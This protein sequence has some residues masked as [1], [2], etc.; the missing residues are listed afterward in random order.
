MKNY[1]KSLLFVGLSVGFGACTDLDT[2]VDNRYTTLP[3]NPI[4]IDA[5]FN[6]CYRNLHGW[7]GRDYNEGV[8]NQ[9]DEIMGVCY[10][11]GNYY[12]DGRAI[13]GS[14]HSLTLTNWCTRMIMDCMGACTQI[15]SKILAYGGPE[16]RDPIVAPLRAARAYYTFWMMDLYGDVPGIV[17]GRAVVERVVRQHRA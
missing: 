10:T 12:D 9:G 11:L 1:I 2:P 7:F 5:E 15:N 13:N 3:D 17:L 4:I 8:V 14:I 6:S 16:Q